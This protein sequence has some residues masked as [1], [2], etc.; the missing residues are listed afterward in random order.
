MQMKPGLPAWGALLAAVLAASLGGC[1][2]SLNV[3]GDPFVQPDKFHFLRCP[4]VAQ[5]MV[6]TK[7]REQELRTLMDRSSAGTGGSTVNMFVYQPEYRQ[8]QA[9]LKQLR[10]AQV[11]KEC[12]PEPAKPD[13]K[14]AKK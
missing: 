4:D 11:E 2:S 7:A 10:E 8:V 13:A 12:P 14:A 5:R 1:T 6:A 9:D 3:V